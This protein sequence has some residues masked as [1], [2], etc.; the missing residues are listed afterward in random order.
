MARNSKLRE[1]CTSTST[2]GEGR[3]KAKARGVSPCGH[4][5]TRNCAHVPWLPTFSFVYYL[6]LRFWTETRNVF[7]GRFRFPTKKNGFKTAFARVF[8]IF[9]PR[10]LLLLLES[11]S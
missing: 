8:L 1:A 4:L 3:Q 5:E 2:P 6:L 9:V 11:S 10:G 7:D